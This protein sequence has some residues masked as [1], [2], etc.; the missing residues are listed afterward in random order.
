M[1]SAA[2]Y[3]ISAF[4][5]LMYS[6]RLP[7]NCSWNLGILNRCRPLLKFT[8]YLIYARH[9]PGTFLRFESKTWSFIMRSA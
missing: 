5:P 8:M 9:R 4:P 7:R 3:L 2:T 6:K 1:Q